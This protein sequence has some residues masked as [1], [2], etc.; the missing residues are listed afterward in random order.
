MKQIEYIHR[1]TGKISQEMVPGEKWLQWLYHHPIGKLALHGIVKR[2]V[3][4][5]W[6]G[7]R[8]DSPASKS[9]IPGFVNHLQID[10]T[11]ALE[12]VEAF[13]TFNDFFIRRLK[14]S[15][16][17]INPRPEAL[18]SPADGKVTAFR[19]ITAL[20]TFF[21]KGQTFSIENFLQDSLLSR[22][23]SGGTLVI[24]RL[25]PVDYHRFHFPADGQISRSTAINGA[26]YSVS[27]YAVKK[28][29]SIY[30]ENKREYSVLKT[31]TA[32]DVLMCEVGATMVGTIV[33]SYTPETNVKKG[34][35][36]GWFKFGGSTV[37]VLLEKGKA[38]VDEDLIANTAKGYETTVQMGEQLASAM[39]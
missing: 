26:Y 19:N 31:A 11:E 17:P 24:I 5:H 8:M 30:W 18:V 39:K 27:P 4:T 9:K 3:L 22:K 2:K 33:Q 32:G 38:R 21:A 20:N 1:K 35:E 6:Y 15:A 37:V 25:A 23:Y 28:R 34:E 10:M 36:K 7:Q 16:R 12:P 29:M 13:N 14:P